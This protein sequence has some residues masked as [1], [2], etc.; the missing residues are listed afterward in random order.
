[1]RCAHQ[2]KLSALLNPLVCPVKPP[3]TARTH[4][5]S[6]CTAHCRHAI[7]CPFPHLN[8]RSSQQTRW[9]IITQHCGFPRVHYCKDSTSCR[10]ENEHH[11]RPCAPPKCQLVRLHVTSMHASPSFPSHLDSHSRLN[12]ECPIAP[13][14]TKQPRP[15]DRPS[16]WPMPLVRAAPKKLPTDA[17]FIACGPLQVGH[18]SG[19]L[20][21]LP[22]LLLYL[23]KDSPF[24]FSRSP[25][26]LPF[27]C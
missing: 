8:I 11:D 24:P 1:M 17:V 6:T 20:P 18:R 3:R 22:Y 16:R 7:C 9:D 15:L 12:L 10:L 19:L 5:P 2:Y 25:F 21:C 14:F 26:Y 27:L 13:H 23:D 4:L